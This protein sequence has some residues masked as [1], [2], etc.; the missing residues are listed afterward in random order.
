MQNSDMIKF[1]NDVLTISLTEEGKYDFQ[2]TASTDSKVSA[3]I[4]Y[5]IEII[6]SDKYDQFLLQRSN[7][8]PYFE[9]ELPKELDISLVEQ[10]DESLVDDT[11]FEY[12]SPKLI[13]AE[14]NRIILKV[15]MGD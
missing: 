2:I 9:Q 5:E 7:T 13:D 11:I 4:K 14:N 15:D 1:K 3:T 8:F 10:L 6:Q 12:I